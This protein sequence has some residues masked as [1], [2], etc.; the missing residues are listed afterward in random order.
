MSGS[1]EGQQEDYMRA[2]FRTHIGVLGNLVQKVP[3]IT[4]NAAQET[5][6]SVA[7]LLPEANSILLVGRTIF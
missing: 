2:F 7:D 5:D 1:A 3:D 4:L 6:R